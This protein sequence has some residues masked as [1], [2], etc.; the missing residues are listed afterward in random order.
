M[1]SFGTYQVIHYWCEHNKSL[2]WSLNY[3]CGNEYFKYAIDGKVHMKLSVKAREKH[4]FKA[5]QFWTTF[6]VFKTVWKFQWECPS[7]ISWVQN[8]IE[9]W[10]I[11]SFTIFT[12]Y[13]LIQWKML[14]Y[15]K[16]KRLITIVQWIFVFFI[17][18]NLILKFVFCGF[19]A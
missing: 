5:K 6:F 2:K 8:G 13:T 1:T 17:S 4:H 19:A 11:W 3:N 10:G 12:R 9:G 16:S 15:H 14:C 7:A 18:L